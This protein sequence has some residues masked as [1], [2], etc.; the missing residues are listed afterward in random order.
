[1]NVQVEH[2][3]IQY[4]SVLKFSSLKD[5]HLVLDFLDTNELSWTPLKYSSRTDTAS[6]RV[7][8]DVL[9]IITHK[10]GLGKTCQH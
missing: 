6:I 7:R 1:M 10:F 4:M 9:I 8:E 2:S 3:I 5:Y